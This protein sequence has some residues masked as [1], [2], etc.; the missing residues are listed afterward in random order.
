MSQQQDQ[1]ALASALSGNPVA[2]PAGA[3]SA[4]SAENASASASAGPTVYVPQVG[5]AAMVFAPAPVGAASGSG[6]VAVNATTAT[7]AR[8]PVQPSVPQFSGGVMNFMPAP[9]VETKTVETKMPL[10]ILDG[11][12]SQLSQAVVDQRTRASLKKNLAVKMLDKVDKFNGTN[13]LSWKMGVTSVFKAM[14]IWPHFTEDYAAAISANP[15]AMIADD[16]DFARLTLKATVAAKF[17]SQIDGAKSTYQAWNKL[18]RVYASKMEAAQLDLWKRLNMVKATDTDDMEDHI[19][20]MELMRREYESSG[21][22]MPDKIFVIIVLQSLPSSYSLL[23][24]MLEATPGG[25]DLDNVLEKVRY[26]AT[27]RTISKRAERQ[28]DS[29]LSSE[30]R[31]PGPVRPVRFN[32]RAHPQAGGKDVQCWGCQRYGHVKRDC[33]YRPENIRRAFPGSMQRE[34][35]RGRGQN[36]SERSTRGRQQGQAQPTL[37]RPTRR[38]P[39]RNKPTFNRNQR[40][41]AGDDADKR[42]DLALIIECEGEQCEHDTVDSAVFVIDSGASRHITHNKAFLSDYE[43]LASPMHINVAKTTSSMTAYGSGCIRAVFNGKPLVINNVLWVPGSAFHLISVKSV[44]TAGARVEF[45]RAACVIDLPQGRIR[46][47]SRHGELWTLRLQVTG[48]QEYSENMTVVADAKTPNAAT[49]WHARLGHPSSNTLKTIMKDQSY[50]VRFEDSGQ[51]KLEQWCEA[52]ASGKST[53]TP[54]SASRSTRATYPLEQV[55]SDICGPINPQTLRGFRYFISFRDDFTHFTWVF[56][57][58]KKS[59]ATQVFTDWIATVNKTRGRRIRMLITDQGGEYKNQAMANLCRQNGIQQVFTAAHTHEQVG[60]SERFNRTVA[61]MM[62]TIAIQANFAPR[63]WGELCMTATY[64]I[65]RLPTKTLDGKSP[66]EAWYGIKASLSHLRVIGSICYS[67]VDKE[68]RRGKLKPRAIKCRLLGYDDGP[69]R[70]YR[71]ESLD[72]AQRG[73]VFTSRHVYFNE[74]SVLERWETPGVDVNDDI[75][76]SSDLA[77]PERDANENKSAKFNVFWNDF[78]ADI[79]DADHNEE[80]PLDAQD[81]IGNRHQ[82]IIIDDM[83]IRD[84]NVP[85]QRVPDLHRVPDLVDISDD[86]KDD[87]EQDHRQQVVVNHGDA[88]DAPPLDNG[89]SQADEID[90]KHAAQDDVQAIVH[91]DVEEDADA[92]EDVDHKASEHESDAEDQIS[93]QASSSGSQDGGSDSSENESIAQPPS[94]VVNRPQRNAGPPSRFGDFI[95]TANTRHQVGNP[96]HID[97]DED[98]WA[99]AKQAELDAHAQR[100]T[101]ILRNAAQVNGTILGSR[102]VLTHKIL[103][104]GSTKHKARLVAQGHRQRPGQDFNVDDIYSPVIRMTTLRTILSL[105]AT[106]RWSLDQLDVSTAYLHADLIDKVFMR[107]PKELNTQQVCELRKAIY[108]LRQSGKR[109]FDTA[110]SFLKSQGFRQSQ[111]DRGLFLKQEGN[112]TSY[113]V[114]FVDDFILASSGSRLRQDILSAIKKRFKVTHKTTPDVYIGISIRRTQDFIKLHQAPYIEELLERYDM[115]SCR[116]IETPWA[117]RPDV[118][119]ESDKAVNVTAMREIVGSLQYIAGATRPDIAAP[120]HALAVVQSAPTMAHWRAAKRVL[121]YLQHTKDMGIIYSVNGK[122]VVTGYVD[123]DHA[124]DIATRKSTTGYLYLLNGGPISWAS[125]KQAVVATST[126]EAEY[127]AASEAAKDAIHLTYLMEELRFKPKNPIMLYEDNQS[128]LAIVKND[129]FSARTKH[130]DIHARFLQDIVRNNRLD[131]TYVA[132]DKNVSDL[133]TKPIPR[134]AFERLRRAM[135]IF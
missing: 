16:D 25:L 32:D 15:A 36:Q 2:G 10:M 34:R 93:Q 107:P 86:E 89:G 118:K 68:E 35:G 91:Q 104:D 52:C 71:L 127:L 29:A 129:S 92:P 87:V 113:L 63:Y 6:M 27:K 48:P 38:E 55:F 58:K 132:T 111:L 64:L 30:I 122:N 23:R 40:E 134:D 54:F 13:Y 85:D 46:S 74:A 26:E 116:G 66:Y 114:L 90:F 97:N 82:P 102:W 22:E 9:M 21:G 133:L 117:V 121:R 128:C 101:W 4:N 41:Q 8:G 28:G 96:E 88:E 119:T 33:T 126:V 106:Q 60:A 80:Q 17:Q 77:S 7:A 123:A 84:R 24:T 98:E 57:L 99:E 103:P 47:T 110:A 131:M 65:N 108:G 1:Q 62:R 20:K 18:N 120:V 5:G 11:D 124:G 50:G 31:K 70:S 109:W 79:D 61:D 83:D 95:L 42:D 72:Q 100:G 130:L 94:N 67:H 45:Q 49:L 81:N 105:A 69:L 135:G 12:S 112:E 3:P 78:E 76:G 56:L 43:P 44:V 53:K 73:R 14:G 59:E 125:R 51:R 75:N 19:G 37:N 39:T 115:K